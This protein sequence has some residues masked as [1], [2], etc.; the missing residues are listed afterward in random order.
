MN[1]LLFQV[2]CCHK[3]CCRITFPK[4]RKPSPLRKASS[5]PKT[6]IGCPESNATLFL[7]VHQ[8]RFH[9]AAFGLQKK[10]SK[11]GS[12]DSC[13]LWQSNIHQ[14]MISRVLNYF[15]S[16]IHLHHWT[17]VLK[18]IPKV[19]FLRRQLLTLIQRSGRK[20]QNI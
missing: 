16:F 11:G 3:E 8:V 14:V 6:I 4:C 12:T 9:Q 7:L 17:L 15:L 2:Y 18:S 1:V 10:A 5:L 20:T 13:V 19:I